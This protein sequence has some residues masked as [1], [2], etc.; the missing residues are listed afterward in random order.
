MEHRLKL[1]KTSSEPLVD[2]MKYHSI[3]GS[4]KYLVNTR[5]DLAFSVGYVSRFLSHGCG[6]TYTVISDRD[7]ELG[8]AIQEGARASCTDRLQ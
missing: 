6:E 1:S 2:A 8:T 5:P 3:V 4:L 7:C